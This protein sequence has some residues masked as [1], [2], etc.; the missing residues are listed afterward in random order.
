MTG[1]DIMAEAPIEAEV[2]NGNPNSE[3]V[4]P[5][6][7]IPEPKLNKEV[8]VQQY[9]G[10]PIVLHDRYFLDPSSPITQLDA[11][12]AK[13]YSVKD[14]VH[15]NRSLFALICNTDLPPRTDRVEI[16]RDQKVDGLI[17][18]ADWGKLNWPLI[19]KQ[20]LALIY[21]R[22]LGGLVMEAFQNKILQLNEIE[23][24]KQIV[25]PL[26]TGIKALSAL[27]HVHRAIRPSNIFFMEAALQNLVLGN[28]LTSPCGFDQPIMF[29]TIERSIT[30]PGGRGEGDL[31]DD[32][33]ALGAT[34]VLF[35][36][37]QNHLEMTGE[38][39]LLNLKLE[40]GS[41]EAICGN[42]T[43]PIIFHEPLKGMLNDNVN[44]R[45]GIEELT[46]WVEGQQQL[47][48]KQVL[49]IHSKN[50]YLF[51]EKS[52]YNTRALSLFLSRHN[53]TALQIITDKNL[54]RWLRMDVKDKNMADSMAT[55]IK[56]DL[57]DNTVDFV[58]AKACMILYPEAPISYKGFSF[59][60]DGFGAALAFDFLHRG[61]T[62]RPI[63][64]IS[65]SLPQIWYSFQKNIF[66]SDTDQKEKFSNLSGYLSLKD[67]GFGFERCL[68]KS[69]LT[70]SCQS[71][72]I[73]T[74]YVNKIEDLLPALDAA[75]GRVPNNINPIDRHIAAFIAVHFDRDIQPH[76]RALAD[77]SEEKSTM[78]MLSLL[79][80]L[81]WK[82]QINA[83]YG[84][85]SW[86]G[87]LLGPAINT[88]HSRSKRREIEKKIPSLVRNGSLPELFDLIEN[89]GDRKS[90]AKGFEEATMEYAKAEYEIQEI[91]DTKE[92]RR[93]IAD[94]NG[95]QTA[96]VV[97]VV[98]A[99][100][101]ASVLTIINLS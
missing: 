83:L 44:A 41:Y 18:L 15:T 67:P 85:S 17:P 27:G 101:V 96:A 55:I 47:P 51:E 39:E 24:Q 12:S 10:P 99:M 64:A 37:G 73:A 48:V 19:G 6:E 77:P 23:I 93:L 7:I 82:L 30:S 9:T 5:P 76:M 57:D 59:M 92:E 70:F 78:G 72:I 16:V 58:I 26:I 43:L 84:L 29:E 52:F 89:P 81:Q 69:N 35:L 98:I 68:Y 75:S 33:Y 3:E 56:K 34:I 40:K 80:F 100:I 1:I 91:K 54:I 86:I 49:T 79:A 95:K 14:S 22:P 2:G 31:A 74:D 4:L 88:Y 36:L 42:A 53:E 20:S 62:E 90:D 71:E 46:G 94:I 13:A 60:P 61:I 38:E 45:W 21:E 32:I 63:E 87:G 28:C 97:S 8:P 25:A 50:P 65:L 11:P 66:S